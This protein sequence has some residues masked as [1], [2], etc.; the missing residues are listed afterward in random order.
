MERTTTIM[1]TSEKQYTTGPIHIRVIPVNVGAGKI[2][3]PKVRVNLTWYSAESAALAGGDQTTGL[4]PIP[5]NVR[6]S[7]R[8]SVTHVPQLGK[9]DVNL[10]S[11]HH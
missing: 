3:T 6:L 7:E 9:P 4:L 5:G 2:R 8:R 1:R 10:S 11:A